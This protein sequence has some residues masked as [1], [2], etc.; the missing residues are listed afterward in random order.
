M[1]TES[2]EGLLNTE[3]TESDQVLI[4]KIFINDGYST[5]VNKKS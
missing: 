4:I 2:K 3:L 1:N 5:L